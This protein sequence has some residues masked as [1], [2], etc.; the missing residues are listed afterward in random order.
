VNQIKGKPYKIPLLFLIKHE[1]GEDDEMM[2]I[3]VIG[4][5]ALKMED[6]N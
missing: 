1:Y 3:R 5:P 4:M 2:M 6:N